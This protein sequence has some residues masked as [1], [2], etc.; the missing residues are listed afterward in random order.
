MVICAFQN[1]KKLIPYSD[2]SSFMKTYPPFSGSL[3]LENPNECILESRANVPSI[4]CIGESSRLDHGQFHSDAS[5]DFYEE[6]LRD[7]GLGSD[8]PIYSPETDHHFDDAMLLQFPNILSNHQSK[9]PSMSQD[10]QSSPAIALVDT[11]DVSNIDVLKRWRR[12]FIILKKSIGASGR[13]HAQKKRKISS[14]VH[15]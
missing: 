7:P 9:N 3:G 13:F 6:L 8:Y 11:Q 15:K 2:E 1:G 10:D 14:L 12:V 4:S 5:M